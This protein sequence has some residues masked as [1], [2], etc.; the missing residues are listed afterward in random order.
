MNLFVLDIGCLMPKTLVTQLT[1]VGFEM[2]VNKV[3]LFQVLLV[4]ELLKADAAS[5]LLVFQM[6]DIYV[7][8]KIVLR[9]IFH[10]ALL[11]IAAIYSEN[12]TFHTNIL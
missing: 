5:C 4:F 7:P 2:R 10:A 1:C 3:M 11:K 12:C 8:L 9:S 6:R